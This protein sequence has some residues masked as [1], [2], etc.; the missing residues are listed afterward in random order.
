MLKAYVGVVSKQ[1]LAIF[2]PERDD[3][4]SLVRRYVR[5]GFRRFGFWAILND[6]EAQTIHALFVSG[7]HREAMTALDQCATEIGP[8]PDVDTKVAI[9]H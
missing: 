6:A 7:N 1:G 9:V 4:L 8:I 2:Q 5:Q 3:T